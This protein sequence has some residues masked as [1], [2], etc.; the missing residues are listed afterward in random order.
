[1]FTL[2]ACVAGLWS[3]THTSGGGGWG[4]TVAANVLNPNSSLFTCRDAEG[5]YMLHH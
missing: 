3:T 4:S 5:L 2:V 1:M